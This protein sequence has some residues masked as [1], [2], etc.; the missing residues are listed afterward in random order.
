M[1]T[2]FTEAATP[3]CAY[4][5]FIAEW[6]PPKVPLIALPGWAIIEFAPYGNR[7]AIFQPE[8]ASNN[9]MVVSDGSVNRYI[10]EGFLPQGT[11]V[12]YVG[13]QGTAFEREG[14]QFM[15]VPRNE[16]EMYI[17]KEAHAK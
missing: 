14:R 11:E 15:R 8:D 13:T 4:E 16:I 17:P 5:R 1:R 9:A 7:G 6:Q 10:A 3:D 2:V 12:I